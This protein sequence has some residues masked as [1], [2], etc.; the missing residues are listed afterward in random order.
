MV[1][2][3]AF[4]SITWEGEA[5]KPHVW[6]QLGLQNVFQ[7]SQDYKKKPWLKH[8]PGKS[9]IQT[10]KD[11]FY[12]WLMIYMKSKI[13]THSDYVKKLPRGTEVKL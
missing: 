2:V 11:T 12:T 13:I 7:D 8:L 10:R 5:E 6:G 9:S 1:V 3:H 4:N